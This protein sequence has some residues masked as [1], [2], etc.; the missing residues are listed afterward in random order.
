MTKPLILSIAIL[1]GLFAW[2]S[3][4]AKS[5]EMFGWWPLN[6]GTGDTANDI[7]GN[8]LSALINNFDFGGLGD[9]GSAWAE[10]PEL[11][12]VLSFN[13]IDNSGA[14]AVVGDPPNFGTLP[15]FTTE[16]DSEFTWSFWAKSEQETNN[17][18]ILGNRYS[19]F[20]GDFAPRQFIKFTTS[21]FGQNSGAHDDS[22][23]FANSSVPSELHTSK[24]LRWA[25]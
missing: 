24:S 8:D 10:D 16:E 2:T 3:P 1:T 11:G 19:S 13:G 15:L 22:N 7:S 25:Y 12:T 6:E 23:S 17:D 18:I 4:L 14:Y 21:K 20:G 9:G 5:Q